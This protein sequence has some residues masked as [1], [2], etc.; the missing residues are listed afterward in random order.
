MSAGNAE[1]RADACSPRQVPVS[2]ALGK[3]PARITRNS[4]SVTKSPEKRKWG[5]GGVLNAS[6]NP[7]RTWPSANGW[8]GP[9]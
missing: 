7:P 9:K 6:V 3:P 4:L 8:G 2:P 5:G 1:G